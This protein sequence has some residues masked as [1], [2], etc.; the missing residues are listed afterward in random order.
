MFESSHEFERNPLGINVFEP[1]G[2][3]TIDSLGDA[4]EPAEGAEVSE[5]AG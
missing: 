1:A 5:G 2:D 3:I 4:S